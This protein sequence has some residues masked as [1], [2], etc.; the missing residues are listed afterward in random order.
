MAFR[1][2]YLGRR[3]RKQVDTYTGTYPNGS[4][5]T[6]Y[7]RKFVWANWLM[8]M[9]LD[10]SDNVVRKYTWGCASSEGWRVQRELVPSG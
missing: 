10:G 1:Y 6:T 8:L 4:W 9:E 2:D 7:V 3:I 5:S